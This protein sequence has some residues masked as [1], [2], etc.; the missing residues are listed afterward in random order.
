MIER[1]YS[2]SLHKK[3]QTYVDCRAADEWLTFSTFKAWMEVQDWRE[4]H[5][6]KDMLFPGNKTYSPETCVFIPS[7]LNRFL[8][9]QLPSRGSW[10]LGVHLHQCGKYRAMC[11]NPFTGAQDALGLFYGAAEAHEAW[12]AKKH[13][14]ALRYADMQ[15]DQ[16]IAQALRT[17]FIQKGQDHEQC[18]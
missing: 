1:C 17:R 4:K 14:H 11:S 15:T 13:E 7:Q 3:Y 10:P 9:D 6:D 18:L 8:V 5:L 2:E 12:R 16:R